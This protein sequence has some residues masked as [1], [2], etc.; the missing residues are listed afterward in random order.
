MKY[1]EFLK[2]ILNRKEKFNII[3]ISILMVMNTLF[4]LMS[5]GIILPIVTIL[6]KKDFDFLPENLHEFVKG[7][8]YFD[9]VKYLMLGIILIYIVKNLFIIFY[10]YQQGLFVRNLQ[11]RVVGDLFEKYVFQ[12]YSF[13]LQK[14]TG[15]ILRNIDVSRIVSFGTRKSGGTFSRRGR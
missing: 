4:E 2:K 9:L 11:I 13:F 12:N 3:Y 1:I 6:L 5:I 15:T 8:D 10:N 14:N 7:L